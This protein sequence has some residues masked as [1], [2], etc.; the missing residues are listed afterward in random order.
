MAGN[1][2]WKAI[3]SSDQNSTLASPRAVWSG[4]SIF[5]SLDLQTKSL[6]V[7]SHYPGSKFTVNPYSILK[8]LSSFSKIHK[9]NRFHCW[10]YSI[11]LKIKRNVDETS[12]NSSLFW[13]QGPISWKTNFSMNWGRGNGLGTIEE[14]Y[15]FCAVY[16]CY[17]YYISSLSDHQAL[18]PG[19][20]GLLA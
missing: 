16:F 7:L 8:F 2:F 3:V 1:C 4:P 19:V 15:T 20:W 14:N 17:Y 18:D 6:L 12:Q 13:H 11:H 10:V 9:K 5:L